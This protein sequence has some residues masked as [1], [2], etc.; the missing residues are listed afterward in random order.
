[1]ARLHPSPDFAG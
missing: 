1:M